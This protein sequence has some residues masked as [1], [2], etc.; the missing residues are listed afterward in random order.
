MKIHF[1]GKYIF[2]YIVYCSGTL[3]PHIGYKQIQIFFTFLNFVS[4]ST[5]SFIMLQNSEVDTCKE[6]LVYYV[7]NHI[8]NKNR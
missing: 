6:Y 8:E 4:K 3:L 1:E 7:S 5:L 2:D